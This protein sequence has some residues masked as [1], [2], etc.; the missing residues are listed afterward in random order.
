MRAFACCANVAGQSQPTLACAGRERASKKERAKWDDKKQAL[1]SRPR[2]SARQPAPATPLSTHLCL[3]N[4]MWL[5]QARRAL[6]IENCGLFFGARG[7][8]FTLRSSSSNNN[9]SC[10]PLCSPLVESTRA[11]SSAA[12]AAVHRCGD[13]SRTLL[14]SLIG[15]HQPGRCTK[16]SASTGSCLNRFPKSGQHLSQAKLW[17]C[18]AE[19]WSGII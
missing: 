3:G 10:P 9:N 8:K 4:A 17:N 19:S 18:G 13:L 2:P 15:A 6:S 7:N 12:A 5:Y 1:P 11:Q 16:A 14:L